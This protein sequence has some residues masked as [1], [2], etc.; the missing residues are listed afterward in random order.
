MRKVWAG[1]QQ[2]KERK[3]IVRGMGTRNERLFL[4]LAQSGFE[5]ISGLGRINKR[6]IYFQNR[7]FY[8]SDIHSPDDF[9]FLF[10]T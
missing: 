4:R 2:A 6:L 1:S 3:G 8:S 7:F 5:L 9:T 10:W